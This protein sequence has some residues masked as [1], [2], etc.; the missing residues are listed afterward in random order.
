MKR[1]I[2]LLV[3]LGL[4][5]IGT[6]PGRLSAAILQVN[7]ISSSP[8]GTGVEPEYQTNVTVASSTDLVNAG[9]LTLSGTATA[10]FSGAGSPTVL[11]DG[12]LGAPNNIPD[13]A[14]DNTDGSYTLTFTLSTAFDPDGYDIT[15]IK[16]VAGY[17]TARVS[18][19]YELFYSTIYNPSFVSLGTFFFRPTIEAGYKDHS[20]LIDLTDSSGVIVSNVV[21][22][23]FSVLPALGSFDENSET[24]YREFD[25]F[26]VGSVP[27][28]GTFALLTVGALLLCR[29]HKA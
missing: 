24:A 10:G 3:A 14:I 7:T 13:T 5:T 21:Q 27:E 23:R 29:R 4:L 17:P 1:K 16:T 2:C 22:L 11:N 12:T 8:I 26:G 28:P 20:T 25:V 15:E 18:Q 19:T 6:L 9:Q